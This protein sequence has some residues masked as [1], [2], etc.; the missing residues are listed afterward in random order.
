MKLPLAWLNLVHDRRRLLGSAGGVGLAVLLMLLGLGFW[1]ALRDG[2]VALVRRLDADLFLLSRTRYA[3]HLEK[4]FPCARLAQAAALP[5]VAEVTPLWLRYG[6]AFWKNRDHPDA[7][8]PPLWPIRI[9]AAPADRLATLFRAAP[10]V[11]AAAPLL[12]QPDAMLLDVRSKRFYDAIARGLLDRPGPVDLPRELNGT[13]MRVVGKFRLG[14]DFTAD[15]TV[16]MSTQALLRVLPGEAPLETVDLGLLKLQ[17]GADSEQVARAARTALPG[18]VVLL[19]RE[20]LTRRESRFWL[21]STP[22]GFLFTVGMVVALAVGSVLCYRVIAADAARRLPEYATLKAL[23]YTDSQ[24]TGLALREGLIRAGI[25]YVVALGL[26]GLLYRFLGAWTG[27][28]LALTF[29]R[30][31]FVL[32][33]TATAGAAAAF[34]ALRR[35]RA[36][37]PAEVLA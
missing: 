27:L 10:E 23:G 32:A 36:A 4:A 12:R 37:D 14:T 9:L 34:L 11:A 7:N 2:S 22:T 29:G 26:G 8:P 17:P 5:G 33:L 3:L 24:V 18:D 6:K 31:V 30:A 16:L 21:G 1:Y 13:R 28:P 35:V 25:G 20:A 19:T 15:G